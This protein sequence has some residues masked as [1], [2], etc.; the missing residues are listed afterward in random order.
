MF[1]FRAKPKVVP[2]SGPFKLKMAPQPFVQNPLMMEK[3]YIMEQ[4][5]KIKA[6]F[7]TKSYKKAS[8][9]IQEQEAC[10]TI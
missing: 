10:V 5:E 9:G 1:E 8:R 7:L 6:E 2:N 3:V 4:E